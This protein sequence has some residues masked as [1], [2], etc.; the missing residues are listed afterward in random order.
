MSPVRQHCSFSNAIISFSDRGLAF[1]PNVAA[2]SSDGGPGAVRRRR[3]AVASE[4]GQQLAHFQKV[5]NNLCRS[6][7]LPW[8]NFGVSRSPPGAAFIQPTGS[9]A[10]FNLQA[11]FSYP[12]AFASRAFAWFMEF[13][14]AK[15]KPAAPTARRAYHGAVLRIPDAFEQM[16]QCVFDVLG[17]FIQ[18][19]SQFMDRHGMVQQKCD[20]VLAKHATTA[21]LPAVARRG[22]GCRACR[23]CAGP[24][25]IRRG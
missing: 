24:G 5:F 3:Q 8:C 20:V 15:G 11:W 12:R 9:V 2:R 14:A 4:V 7:R 18:Q 19:R 25:D 22:G 13:V 21:G 17:R 23:R 6:R 1:S 16:L 10:F